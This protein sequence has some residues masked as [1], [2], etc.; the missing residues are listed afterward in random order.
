[1]GNSAG[2]RQAKR[3]MGK[4]VGGDSVSKTDLCALELKYVT[5]RQTLSP[6]KEGSSLLFQVKETAAS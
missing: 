5:Q 1:M 4:L 2:S 6:K 3:S